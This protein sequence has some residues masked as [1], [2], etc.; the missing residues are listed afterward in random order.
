MTWLWNSRHKSVQQNPRFLT[1][2]PFA[3]N[4]FTR[5]SRIAVMT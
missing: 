2:R 4:R 1:F 5:L 3:M